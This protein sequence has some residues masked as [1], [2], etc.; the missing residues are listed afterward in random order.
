[1][2]D[3]D[4]EQLF[5]GFCI[6]DRRITTTATK[7]V[8]IVCLLSKDGNT[9]YLTFMQGCTDIRSTTHSK[10]E[11]FTILREKAMEIANRIDARGFSVSNDINLGSNLTELAELYQQGTIF[12]KAYHKNAIP[13]E[14][15]LRDDLSKMMEIY[16]DYSGHPKTGTFDSWEIVD[17]NTAIKHCDKSFFDYN[18]SGVPKE[19]C[20]SFGAEKLEQGAKIQISLIYDGK[21]FNGRILKEPSDWRRV[22][23]LWGSDL[24]KLFAEHRNVVDVT[25]TLKK[26]QLPHILFIYRT[27]T[28]LIPIVMLGVPFAKEVRKS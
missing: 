20:W 18:G 19:I 11:T 9:L 2:W 13:S 16:T 24:G 27:A 15:E 26:Q 1:M 7:G 12:Y 14:N 5:L 21:Q 4:N 22:Q 6:F 28:K 10:R 25:A 17:E 8:Y 23:I 3:K